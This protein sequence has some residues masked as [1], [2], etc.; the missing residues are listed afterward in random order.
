MSCSGSTE[1]LTSKT[2]VPASS[3]CRPF[4]TPEIL[5]QERGHRV[6]MNEAIPTRS[7]RSFSVTVRP[8]RSSSRNVPSSGA[9]GP[10][11]WAARGTAAR[12]GSP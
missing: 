12:P 1:M 6:K 9:A 4:I 10:R 5:G 2:F 3:P 8:D 11:S 7:A